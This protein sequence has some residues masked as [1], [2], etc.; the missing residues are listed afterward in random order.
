MT[1]L[2]MGDSE[3]ICEVLRQHKWR[4]GQPTWGCEIGIHRAETS[5]ALLRA[6]PRLNLLMVDSWATFPPDHPY[7]LSGDGCS[8]L[9]QAEQDDNMRAAYGAVAFAK[10]RALIWRKES[11]EA[12]REWRVYVDSG[13][14]F[15]GFVFID[16]SHVYEAVAEDI[17][18]W[19]PLVRR[20][21]VL[22]GHDY[23]HRRD[24][25]GIWGV[26]RAVNEFVEREGLKLDLFGTVWCVKKP[27]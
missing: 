13:D 5:A 25:A 14:E 27:L 6:F 26:S 9:T 20:G 21:G 11:A 17:R 23:F 12:A 2:E 1:Q 15:F 3:L 8:R 19:W 7:R 16:A 24:K 18:L 22:G 10:S 4:R